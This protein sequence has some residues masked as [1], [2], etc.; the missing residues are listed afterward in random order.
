[1]LNVL[2]VKGLAVG[3]YIICFKCSVLGP[4]ILRLINLVSSPGIGLVSLCL[5]RSAQSEVDTQYI[6]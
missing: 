5:R 3:R 6:V 4:C 1:M 2:A